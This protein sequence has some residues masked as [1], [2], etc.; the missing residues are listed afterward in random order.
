MLGAVT[1]AFWILPLLVPLPRTCNSGNM[2]HNELDQHTNLNILILERLMI[3]NTD[4][5]WKHVHAYATN[6]ALEDKK[7]LLNILRIVNK[8][9]T[10]RHFTFPLI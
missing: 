6:I 5:R 10:N 3:I 9:T 7:S 8:N 4:T 2:C 1:Q